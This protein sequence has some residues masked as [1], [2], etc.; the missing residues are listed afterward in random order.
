MDLE[1]D[2]RWDS[3]LDALERVDVERSLSC[4]DRDG[5][6]LSVDRGDLEE[7]VQRTVNRL[8]K[9]FRRRGEVKNKGGVGLSLSLISREEERGAA[10]GGSLVLGGRNIADG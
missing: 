1:F 4:S 3:S 5:F 8:V 9:L 10:M 6:F 2:N 7:E